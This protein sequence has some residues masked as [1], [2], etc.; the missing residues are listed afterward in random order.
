MNPEIKSYSI[1]PCLVE[2]RTYVTRQET[3]FGLSI[4][5]VHCIYL[6]VQN[7]GEIIYLFALV[8]AGTYI[9]SLP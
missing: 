2:Q 3:H 8:E 1:E 5:K 4:I 6:A 9:P 7:D